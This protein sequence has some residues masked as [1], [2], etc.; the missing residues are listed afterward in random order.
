MTSEDL[1]DYLKSADEKSEKP[2]RGRFVASLSSALHS[3]GLGIAGFPSHDQEFNLQS[4]LGASL[5]E[6]LKSELA[7]RNR[8]FASGMEMQLL[9]ESQSSLVLTETWGLLTV[10]SFLSRFRLFVLKNGLNARTHF[11]CHACWE[12]IQQKISGK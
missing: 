4:L 9:R 7:V 3:N 1:D 2:L 6:I 11:L 5:S 12:F 8:Q 10:L